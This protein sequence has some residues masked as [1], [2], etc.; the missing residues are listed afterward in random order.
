MFWQKFKKKR[1][2]YIS[3]LILLGL[4]IILVGLEWL[5]NDK[6][7]FINYEHTWHFPVLKAYPETYF[8]GTLKTEADYKNPYVQDLITKKDGKIIWPLIRYSYASLDYDMEAPSPSK[9]STRHLLGTDTYGRDLLSYT[10]YSVRLSLLFGLILTSFSIIIGIIAGALQG[11][12][13]GWTDLIGQRFLEIWSGLPQLF[14]LIILAGIIA[15]SFTS[16]LLIL[17]VFSWTALVGPVRAEFLKARNLDYVRAAKALG[18][19]NIMIML[20]H[21]LPNAMVATF[22]FAPF[23]LTG[24]MVALA[25][26]DYLGL[27]LPIGSA[28]LG[29]ILRQGKENI[30]AP[31]IGLTGFFVMGFVL[32]LLMF[33]AEGLRDTFSASN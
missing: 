15:P 18:V 2:S 3:S 10:L 9:P 25:S 19:S 17:L 28:S 8:G 14:I 5:A 1:L 24:S 6:P 20:R 13:G 7:I 29:E 4:S 33:I 26:L 32:S 31:W 27:G 12:F 22:T 23:I 16:L 21:I 11:Y 30:Q